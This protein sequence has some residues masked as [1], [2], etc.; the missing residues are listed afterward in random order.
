MDHA[1]AMQSGNPFETF[2]Q[3][4]DGHAGFQTAVHFACRDDSFGDVGPASFRHRILHKGQCVAAKN[5]KQIKA[6][7]PLHLKDVDSA[8]QLKRVNRNKVIHLNASHDGRDFG[9]AMHFFF[10]AGQ[11]TEGGRR[12]KLESNRN[13]EGRRASAFSQHHAALS[14]H[15]QPLDKRSL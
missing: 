8:V 6:I 5:V 11:R 15:T 7:N 10:V 13:T 1:S 4:G 9:E 14:T 12:E 2:T 3:D